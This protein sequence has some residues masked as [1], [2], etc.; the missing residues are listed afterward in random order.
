[1]GEQYNLVFS[2][3]WSLSLGPSVCL[4]LQIPV[5]LFISCSLSV[6]LS[7]YLPAS[8]SACLSV[9]L[10]LSV[11]LSVCLKIPL[12]ASHF[13]PTPSLFFERSLRESLYITIIRIVPFKCH[14][15]ALL[16]SHSKSLLDC[17]PYC[18]HATCLPS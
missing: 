16:H 13:D 7:T 2:F 4:F 10:C 14:S 6:C 5:T 9:C 8:M 1:M 12:K 3:C 17:K 11:S 18:F 15:N